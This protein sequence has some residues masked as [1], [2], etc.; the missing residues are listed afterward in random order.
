MHGSTHMINQNM[1]QPKPCDP[2]CHL[3]NRR[4]VALLPVGRRQLVCEPCHDLKQRGRDQTTRLLRAQSREARIR[5]DEQRRQLKQDH[6]SVAQVPVLP[7]L[8]ANTLGPPIDAAL[9]ALAHRGELLNNLGID[10]AALAIDASN[11]AGAANP[12]EEMLVH[13]MAVMHKVA[14]ESITKAHLEESTEQAIRLMNS[15]IRLMDCFQRGIIT[16]KR[17]RSK[18]EQTIMV[19]HVHVTD[20]GQAVIGTVQ[21]SGESNK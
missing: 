18:S 7:T 10:A 4:G 17:T 1:N 12:L 15:S 20:G 19:Q 5:A 11:A 21:G 16:L 6:G 14:L 13:Q 3:C 8:A 9:D 2:K